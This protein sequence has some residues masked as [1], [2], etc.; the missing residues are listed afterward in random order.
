MKIAKGGDNGLNKNLIT[1]ANSLSLLYLKNLKTMPMRNQWGLSWF[2]RH[3]KPSRNSIFYLFDVLIFQRLLMESY[4]KK[5]G[6]KWK[7]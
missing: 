4:V 3:K 6:G 5:K 2:C 1:S 7:T